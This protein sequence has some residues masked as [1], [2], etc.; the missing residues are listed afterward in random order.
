LLDN[1]T[2]DGIELLTPRATAERGCQ[3]SLRVRRLGRKALTALAAEGVV[4][5]FREPDV[6]RVAPV[7]L[8]NTYHEVWRFAGILGRIAGDGTVN[9]GSGSSDHAG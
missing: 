7:P 3:L 5:D 4:C 6:I 1:A 9:R 2:G 8:Y